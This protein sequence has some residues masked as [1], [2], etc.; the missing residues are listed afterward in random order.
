[1]LTSKLKNDESLVP[2]EIIIKENTQIILLGHYMPNDEKS[3]EVKTA[4]FDTISQMN[5]LVGKI[6]LLITYVYM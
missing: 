3:N 1:M 5:G 4:T 6:F 2:F